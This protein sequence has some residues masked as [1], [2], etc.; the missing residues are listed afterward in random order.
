ML[1]K[2]ECMKRKRREWNAWGHVFLKFQLPDKTHIQTETN[3]NVRM[4]LEYIFLYLREF[5]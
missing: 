5:K 1:S 3:K 2:L 4:Y